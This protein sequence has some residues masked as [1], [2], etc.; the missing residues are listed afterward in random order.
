MATVEEI[1]TRHYDAAWANAQRFWPQVEKSKL[2]FDL[3]GSVAGMACYGQK[4]I[5]LNRAYCV[6]EPVDMVKDTIP[7][8]IAHIIARA[9]WGFGIRPHGA[10]WRGVFT[11]LTGASANR[12]HNYGKPSEAIERT[13]ARMLRDLQRG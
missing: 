8:E 9:V 5:R 11:V 2:S 10:E 6:A 3:T 1:M 7:H 13:A 12:C 4:L